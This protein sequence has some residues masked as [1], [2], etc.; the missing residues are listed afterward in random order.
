VRDSF[1]GEI[2]MIET[3]HVLKLDQEHLETVIPAA[4]GEILVVGGKYKGK[5]V[6]FASLTHVA[7]ELAAR[8]FREGAGSK[9]QKV[10]LGEGELS[11]GGGG[12]GAHARKE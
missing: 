6:W 11:G 5:G 4:G 10:R 9:S 2:K 12:G 7:L 8:E 1:V 3:G